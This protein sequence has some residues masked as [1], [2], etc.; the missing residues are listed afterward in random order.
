MKVIKV[1]ADFNNGSPAADM[2]I[3]STC[4]VDT[5]AAAVRKAELAIAYSRLQF[6]TAILDMI[7]ARNAREDYDVTGDWKSYAQFLSNAIYQLPE[8]EPYVETLAQQLQNAETEY[9][10]EGLLEELYEMELIIEYD[11][12]FVDL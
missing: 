7:D 8:I 5:D 9:Q 1:I 10:L 2:Y 4:N 11:D 3:K 6:T 12:N